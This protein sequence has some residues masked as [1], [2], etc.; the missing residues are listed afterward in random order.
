MDSSKKFSYKWIVAGACFL[1]IFTCLGFCSSVKPLVLAPITAALDIPRALF[2][3]NDTCRYITTSVINIFFGAL[4][5]RFGPKKLIAAGFLCLMGSA[6]CYALAPTVYVFYAGGVLLGLGL[7]WTTTTMVGFVL[8]KW[9]KKNKGTV[10]GAVL[11]ANGL[12]GAT[13]AQVL[14]PVIEKSTFGY[15]N[16]YFII[17]IIL[18]VI[19]VLVATLVR[20]PKATEEEQEDPATPAKKR[21]GQSWIGVDSA[22]VLKKPYTWL[23][24]VCIFLCGLTLNGITGISAAHMR[25]TGLD[26]AYVATVVSC[27]SIALT[28]FKFLTGFLY[29]RFGLRVTVAIST[30]TG[31]CVMVALSCVTATPAGMVLALIYGVFSSLALPL[32]T[33]M[34]PIFANDLFGE[35]SYNK[36]LGI[37]VSVNTAGYA[38]GSLF[39]N[40]CFD[41]MGTYKAGLLVCAVI[42][43]FIICASQLAIGMSNRQKRAIIAAESDPQAE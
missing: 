21:R 14:T 3:I 43:L 20:T 26:P 18:F 9:F 31:A 6:L 13:C 25:D 17:A 32:E 2:A 8:N 12:G 19:G 1:M 7:S 34:L 15:R 30:V 11:A 35:R 4:V 29:D 5:A 37:I 28:G 16:A 24:L 39:M 36:M 27:H 33:V 22:V 23:M 10:M 41:M 42:M 38:A 40:A